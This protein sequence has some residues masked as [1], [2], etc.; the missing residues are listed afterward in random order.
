MKKNVFFGL[1]TVLF[2]FGFI[3]CDKGNEDL[4]GSWLGWNGDGSAEKIWKFSGN[5]FL[6]IIADDNNAKGTFT[7]NETVI[8]FTV[9]HGWDGLKWL[10]LPEVFGV[11]EDVYIFNSE[12]TIVGNKLTIEGDGNGQPF[13]KIQK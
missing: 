6:A 2:V 13:I 4:E 5:E 12:Y 8:T 7:Y 9:T 3:G 11:E 1:L 10:T